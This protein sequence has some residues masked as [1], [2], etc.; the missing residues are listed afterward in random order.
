M[1]EDAKSFIMLMILGIGCFV[2]II[3]LGLSLIYFK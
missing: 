2:I 3:G 1:E